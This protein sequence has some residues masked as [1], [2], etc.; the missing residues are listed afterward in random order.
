M[1]R[2]NQS[3]NVLL[4]IAIVIWCCFFFLFIAFCGIFRGRTRFW[5]QAH[6]SP[7]Y[8][9]NRWSY[10][11]KSDCTFFLRW[12]TKKKKKR[13]IQLIS[14]SFCFIFIITIYII[15]IIH[16]LLLYESE[17]LGGFCSGCVVFFCLCGNLFAWICWIK[18]KLYC[19]K[20]LPFIITF[21]L[22]KQPKCLIR[23]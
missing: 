9:K 1:L 7:G 12:K 22:P 17:W 19:R 11:L 5:S 15:K 3:W 14:I 18:W 4:W 10:S 6:T 2:N 20:K 23:D 21:S 13:S 8:R 16:K